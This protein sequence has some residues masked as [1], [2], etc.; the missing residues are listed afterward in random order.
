LGNSVCKYIRNSAEFREKSTIKIPR[1]SAKFRGIPCV[2]QKIPYSAGSEKSTSVDTL[3]P[4]PLPSPPPQLPLF[5]KFI[6]KAKLVSKMRNKGKIFVKIFDD[7]KFWQIFEQIY[8]FARIFAVICAILVQEAIARG[9]M[10]KFVGVA[11]ISIIIRKLLRKQ[12]ELRYLREN[13]NV[14]TNFAKMTT[15][16]RRKNEISNLR[17]KGKIHFRFNPNP[18]RRINGCIV[19]KCLYSVE[20]GKTLRKLWGLRSYT[21]LSFC[22]IMPYIK[23]EYYPLSE[24]VLKVNP[25]V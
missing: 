12:K 14:R 10:T 19:V 17:A 11:K 21:S 2:F 23:E 1:N 15:K 18:R 9:K 22:T 5:L 25:L 7:M 6:K 24:M 4:S 3:V 13:G 20:R 8:V 16:F